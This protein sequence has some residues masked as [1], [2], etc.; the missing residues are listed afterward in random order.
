M[1]EV[2]TYPENDNIFINFDY[3][4]I[5]KDVPIKSIQEIKEPE[6][7]SREDFAVKSISDEYSREDDPIKSR[8]ETG[9]EEKGEDDEE[10]AEYW[11]LAKQFLPDYDINEQNKIIE[12]LNFWIRSNW[13][14]S[15]EVSNKK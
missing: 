1:I 10:V 9:D 2:M 8:S 12:K 7:I 4:G 6:D 11:D 5:P 14:I 15:R 13:T 3:K